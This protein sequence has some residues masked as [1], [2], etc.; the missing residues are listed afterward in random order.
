MASIAIQVFDAKKINRSIALLENISYDESVVAVKKRLSEKLSLPINR[1][2]LRLDAKGKNLGDNRIIQ[3]LNLPSKGAHL[4]IRD[5][6]PQISWKTV[7]LLEYFGPLVIYPIFYLRPT[8]IY[9]PD[10]DRYP[11]SYGVKFALVCWTLHYAKRLLETQFVH[12]FSNATMPRQNVFKNCSYYWAFAAFVSYFINHP[13]YT[14][15]YFG[16]VQVVGCLIGFLI[17]EFGNLSVHLL[18]RNLRPPGTKVRKIPRPN[19]NPL[20]LMFN[21]VSCPNYTYEVGSWLFFSVMTQALPALIFTFAGFLQMA[22]W[23]KGKHKNY[24]REFPE[25]PKHRRAIVPFVL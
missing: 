12:R 16:S 8:G 6:G 17:C 20:T 1:I 5:L 14:P 15:A 24:I 18:L 11:I 21:F 13:L 4:Y 25:Y 23:A 19:S 7:F 22:I 2:A 3:D 9:G 10:T